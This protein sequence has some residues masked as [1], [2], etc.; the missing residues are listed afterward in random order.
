[1]RTALVH[2]PDGG[3]S[4]FQELPGTGAGGCTAPGSDDFSRRDFRAVSASINSHTYADRV[5]FVFSAFLT[6]LA[7]SDFS[8][9]ICRIPSFAFTSPVGH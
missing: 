5:R 3:G 6:A 1:M 7:L 4:V 8:M 2:A 9:R